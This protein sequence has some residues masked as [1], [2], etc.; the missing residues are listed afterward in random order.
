LRE[1]AA[2]ILVVDDDDAM[3]SA[4]CDVLQL[5]GY[6]ARG[7]QSGAAALEIVKREIPDLLIS[8]LRMAEMSGHQLQQELRT[9]A[10]DLP[11][12]IITAFGTVESAVE[13]MKLGARD[14]VTK[15]FSN[16]D[17][18]VLLHQKTAAPVSRE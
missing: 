7:V 14:F 11:V 17:L 5:A 15:P 9:I 6:C 13:S 2:T 1:Q 10:P 12:L 16:K 3:T 18:L 4:V 8:D